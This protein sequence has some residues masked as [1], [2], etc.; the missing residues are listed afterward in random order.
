MYFLPK[1]AYCRVSFPNALRLCEKSKCSPSTAK[2]EFLSFRTGF[3]NDIGAGFVKSE[4]LSFRTGFQNDIGAGFV[5][6]SVKIRVNP[7]LKEFSHSLAFVGNPEAEGS[8][9]P[10]LPSQGQA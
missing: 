6:V 8:R 4:F 9:F 2:S 3:Q 1:Q 7:W 5:L 10:P